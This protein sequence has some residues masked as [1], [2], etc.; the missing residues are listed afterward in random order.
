MARQTIMELIRWRT[1]L[2]MTLVHVICLVVCYYRIQIL[3]QSR[4]VDRSLTL[5]KDRVRNKIMNIVA[6]SEGRKIIRMSPKAFLDLCSILQQ[7]GGLLP[8]QRVTVE[9]Q[10]AKTLYLLTHNVRNREIQFWF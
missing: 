2:R 1:R 8:T 10:V 4:I 6:T 3:S 7:E 9:E 5:E